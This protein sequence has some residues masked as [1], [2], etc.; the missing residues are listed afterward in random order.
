MPQAETE[1]P[2][3]LFGEAVKKL[4]EGQIVVGELYL[5]QVELE[6]LEV[7]ERLDELEKLEEKFLVVHLEVVDSPKIEGQR[8]QLREALQHD[9]N[10]YHIHGQQLS[11]E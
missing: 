4:F 9:Q 10:A 3:F 6:V 2:E 1:F 11:I 5:R 8:A 7:H